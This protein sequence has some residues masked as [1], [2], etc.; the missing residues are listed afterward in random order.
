MYLTDDPL[1]VVRFFEI[2]HKLRDGDRDNHRV[3]LGTG[4]CLINT[5]CPTTYTV[6]SS[7]KIVVTYIHVC[8]YYVALHDACPPVNN[9]GSYRYLRDQAD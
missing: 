1:F 2:E 3:G 7:C 8:R 4:I 6:P 5:T 9:E